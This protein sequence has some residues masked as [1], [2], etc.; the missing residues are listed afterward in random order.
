[1]RKNGDQVLHLCAEAGQ[2]E[3]FEWFHVNYYCDVNAANEAGETP[4]IIAARE[5]RI[6]IIK[7]YFEKYM[8][9]FKVT[10]KSKDGWTAL[11]Y[12]CFNSYSRVVELLLQHM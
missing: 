3:L 8:D 5:G 4:F 11:M 1:M 12:A 10:T 6:K 9:L 7:L 2:V